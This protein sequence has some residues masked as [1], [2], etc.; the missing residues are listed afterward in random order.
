MKNLNEIINELEQDWERPNGFWEELRGGSFHADE[1]EKIIGVISSIEISEENV[2]KRLVSLLWY[3]PLFM[4][5]QTERVIE[6]GGDAI[7]F[8][9]AKNKLIGILEKKLGVP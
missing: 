9:T 8:E 3:L 6:K 5:W 2:S 4:E 7:R 1:Y